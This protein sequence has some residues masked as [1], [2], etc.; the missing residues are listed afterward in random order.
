MSWPGSPRAATASP[1]SGRAEFHARLIRPNGARGVVARSPFEQDTG[2]NAG[3][4][5]EP[6]LVRPDR[7]IL[8]IKGGA[9]RTIAWFAG[10]LSARRGTDAPA[11]SPVDLA[12]SVRAAGR[13][14]GGRRRPGRLRQGLT[15]DEFEAIRGSALDLP[16]S[17]EI[18]YWVA[19]W[20]TACLAPFPVFCGLAAPPGNRG[21]A[22]PVR[23]H[24]LVGDPPQSKHA[25]SPC[26]SSATPRAAWRAAY[27]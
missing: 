19:A 22:R 4:L 13:G 16:P 7:R 23:T 12:R 6:S 24:A 10:S 21:C 14:P 9:T 5:S 8:T 18:I 25:A 3:N 26:L 20:H 11:G 15:F 2:G 17:R 1:D 27:V